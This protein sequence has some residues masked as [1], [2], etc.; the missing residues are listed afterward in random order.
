MGFGAGG[1]IGRAVES[2][3]VLVSRLDQGHVSGHIMREN[4]VPMSAQMTS[5]NVQ[6]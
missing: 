5:E 2:R 4:R 1:L 3:V 6:Q